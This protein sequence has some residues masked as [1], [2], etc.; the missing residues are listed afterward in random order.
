MEAI[1]TATVRAK[2]LYDEALDVRLLSI[3]F[4]TAVDQ[5]EAWSLVKPGEVQCC[6]D[7][8]AELGDARRAYTMAHLEW[9]HRVRRELSDTVTW[10]ELFPLLFQPRRPPV[11][12]VAELGELP[13]ALA[14]SWAWARAN[15]QESPQRI[16]W[17]AADRQELA[18]LGA[19]D[20]GGEVK[21]PDLVGP[22][23]VHRDAVPGVL[24][25]GRQ[26]MCWRNHLCQ[27]C[28]L[29]IFGPGW[30]VVV[31]GQEHRAELHKST[32]EIWIRE[33]PMHRAC[34]VSA[35][36]GCPVVRGHRPHVM[37]VAR[38]A[39]ELRWEMRG[40]VHLFLNASPRRIWEFYSFQEALDIAEGPWAF[41]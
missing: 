36:R 2:R 21:M 3:R 37:V 12:R 29:G 35:L 33:P 16:P 24:H 6:S 20:P 17:V 27:V 22:G 9:V 15:L 26:A 14:K 7:W 34:L 18:C 31:L 8:R 19:L 11:D 5:L 32:P 41:C 28:G 4:R 1:R 40:G 10:S 13:E 23:G 30:W 38:D 25:P 39:F